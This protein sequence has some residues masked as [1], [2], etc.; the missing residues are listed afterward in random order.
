M[1]L[2]REHFTESV[3]SRVKREMRRHRWIEHGDTIGVAL[4]GG[5]D[6]TS[7]LHFLTKTFG[8]RPDITI[9]A[10]TID[11]GI[12]GYRDLAEIEPVVRRYDVPW[13]TGSFAD[14]YGVTLDDIIAGQKD[15]RRSCSFCGVLRRRIVN[16]IAREAGCTKLAFGFNLD[17]EAQSVLMN[18][19][20]GDAE[21]LTMPQRE[22]PGM[23]PRIRPFAVIPEREVALYARLHVG[24]FADHGCPYAHNAL[25]GDVRQLLNE[26]TWQHPATKYAVRNLGEDLQGLGAGPSVTPD[27]CPRCGEPAF[28]TC[29]TCAVLDEVKRSGER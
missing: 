27:I 4:S 3:E 18:V 20:R 16:R 24:T 6:S 21:R 2:C 14:E 19:L 1:H 9:V 28:G 26:Y 22:N 7:L 25:R 13:H 17:D 5:K 23:I 15:D 29:R 12:E 11:E 8:H 10:I